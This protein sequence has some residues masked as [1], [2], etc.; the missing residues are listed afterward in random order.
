MAQYSWTRPSVVT[1]P[2]S[3]AG[4]GSAEVA[5]I[6]EFDKHRE[7]LLNGDAA[8]ETLDYLTV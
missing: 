4:G 6:S 5:N 3:E 2:L 7:A 8:D 1:E